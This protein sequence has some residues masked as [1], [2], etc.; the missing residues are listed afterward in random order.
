MPTGNDEI[1]LMEM[2]TTG[3]GLCCECIHYLH[4]QIENPCAYNVRTVGYLKT[5]CWRWQS[6]EDSA[7]RKATKVCSRCGK[8][9]SIEM[10]SE[11]KFGADGYAN[12]CDICRKKK[13]EERRKRLKAKQMAQEV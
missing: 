3:R 2:E 12:E 6:S 11:V 7:P 9:L 10:F 13:N 1:K 8:E 4:G 5:G